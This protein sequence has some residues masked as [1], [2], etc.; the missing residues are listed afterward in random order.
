MLGI[1]N[2]QKIHNRFKRETRKLVFKQYNGFLKMCKA[3]A[4]A[5]G[6]KRLPLTTINNFL[7]KCKVETLDLDPVTLDR[8][9][10]LNSTFDTMKNVCEIQS[11]DTI[12]DDKIS[13]S[14][15]SHFVT[16]FKESFIQAQESDVA[17]ITDK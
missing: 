13:I 15:I 4:K 2:N 8:V 17:P 9:K 12:K 5:F 1:S 6:T 3:S 16:K 14:E 11:R 7:E 10:K